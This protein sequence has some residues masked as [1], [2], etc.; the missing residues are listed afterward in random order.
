MAVLGYLEELKRDLGLIFAHFQ[1]DFSIKMF[2]FEYSINEQSFNVTPY[3][4]LKISNKMLLSS[5]REK[6]RGR[7]KY[8]N[9]NISRTKNAF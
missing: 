3:F 9:L 7:Q 4:F 2:L 6:K 1:H 8:E 5:D